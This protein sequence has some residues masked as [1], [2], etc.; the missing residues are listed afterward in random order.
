MKLRL[1]NIFRFFKKLF[2]LQMFWFFFGNPSTAQ[3]NDQPDTDVLLPDST[4][5]IEQPDSGIDR[6][7]YFEHKT[8]DALMD[9][10]QLREVPGK[11]LDSLKNDDAFWYANK[12]FKKKVT[13]E[14][15][16]KIRN[17]KPP[18]Q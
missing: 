5:A 1:I 9:T 7:N 3:N 12:V 15:N 6:L 17:T 11:V 16:I 4:V 8:N 14:E 10:I 2:C 13:K 18:S